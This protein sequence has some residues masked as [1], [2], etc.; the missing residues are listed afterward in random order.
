MYYGITSSSEPILTVYPFQ[1]LTR[2]FQLRFKEGNRI[3]RTEKP[4]CYR[5]HA[6]H[7]TVSVLHQLFPKGIGSSS[8]LASTFFD[9]LS[10]L[11][12]KSQWKIGARWRASR[13]RFN[14]C[15]TTCRPPID[16]LVRLAFRP[17]K[18]DH[19]TDSPPPR[20]AQPSFQSL[21]VGSLL[22]RFYSTM[23]KNS[24]GYYKTS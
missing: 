6:R 20:Q 2:F 18:A 7:P 13:W 8:L 12:S 9:P 23:S 17:D 5:L 14:A 16:P 3:C 4:R 11:F 1:D 10:R 22:T 15:S 24:R 21:S 19:Q